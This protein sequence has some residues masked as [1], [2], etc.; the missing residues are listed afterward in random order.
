MDSDRFEEA[1][2]ALGFDLVGLPKEEAIKLA[3]R[4]SVAFLRKK[5]AE[6][7]D[8]QPSPGVSVKECPVDKGKMHISVGVWSTKPNSPEPPSSVPCHHCGFGAQDDDE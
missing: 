8:Y 2:K 1:K 7:R 5:V 6:M 3:A 4:R